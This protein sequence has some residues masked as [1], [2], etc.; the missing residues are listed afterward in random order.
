MGRPPA[1]MGIGGMRYSTR[2][3]VRARVSC[4]S[5]ASTGRP[6]QARRHGSDCARSSLAQAWW[7]APRAGWARSSAPPTGR[8]RGLG[9]AAAALLW[10]IEHDDVCWP[11]NLTAPEPLRNRDLH[12][13]LSHSPGPPSPAVVPQ[14][15]LDRARRTGATGGTSSIGSMLAEL[16]GASQRAVP[17]ALLASGFRFAAPSAASIWGLGT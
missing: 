9:S 3:A 14:F 10:A 6:P 12:R 8:G 5:C 1:S 2:R 15:L 17:Q 13:L 16:L 7:S 11:V 4:P